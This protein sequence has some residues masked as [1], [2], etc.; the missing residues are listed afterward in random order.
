MLGWSSGAS[1]GGLMLARSSQRRHERRRRRSIGGKVQSWGDS[2]AA[3]GNPRRARIVQLNVDVI[4]GDTENNLIEV[5][6]TVSDCDADERKS[7]RSA[8]SLHKHNQQPKTIHARS[9]E[10]TPSLLAEKM[11]ADDGGHGQVAG[12]TTNSEKGQAYSTPGSRKKLLLE[13]VNHDD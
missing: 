3:D 9:F 10:P 7:S 2:D 1:P 6:D 4:Q 13:R 12:E 5:L 11:R 8:V